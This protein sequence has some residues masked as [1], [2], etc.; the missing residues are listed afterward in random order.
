[1]PFLGKNNDLASEFS[2]SNDQRPGQK[3]RYVYT[4]RV[5]GY[6]K[7]KP[8][9]DGIIKY[10]LDKNTTQTHELGRGRFCGESV[11]APLRGGT[12]EDKG[13][14]LTLVWDAVEKQPE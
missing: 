14:L 6:M 1:M 11:F 2:R 9:F 12:A 8:L 10:D 3:M 13:W 7:P 5:A 4:S